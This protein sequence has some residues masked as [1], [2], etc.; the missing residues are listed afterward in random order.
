V[1][2]DAMRQLTEAYLD[3]ET[4]GLSFDM[5][6]ITVIGIYM[7]NDTNDRF[8]QL[9]GKQV[10]RDNLLNAL[11]DVPKI[12]TYNGKRFDLPF[13]DKHLCIDLETKYAHH[14]LLFDCWKHNL[15]GGFKAVERQLEIP[16][17]LPN[18]DGAK[19]VMLWWRYINHQDLY[20][21]DLLLEYNKEDVVNLKKLKE[22]LANGLV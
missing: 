1:V 14:D 3:I 19:A 15:R 10:T 11:G 5:N 18:I 6:F 12:Y 7:C 16:R 17:K 8:V 21:L 22:R 13:I 20:A 9:F 4:T 2:T